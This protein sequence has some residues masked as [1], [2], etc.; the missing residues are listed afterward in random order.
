MKALSQ[1]MSQFTAAERSVM[2]LALAANAL[3]EAKVARH[4]EKDCPTLAADA[5]H[6]AKLSDSLLRELLA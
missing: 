4:L 6:A 2:R 5:R 1:R 3:T